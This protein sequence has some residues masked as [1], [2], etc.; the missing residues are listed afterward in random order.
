MT[1][2]KCDYLGRR[3]ATVTESDFRGMLVTEWR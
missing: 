3:A 2:A 1:V